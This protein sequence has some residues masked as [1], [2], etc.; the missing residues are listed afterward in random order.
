MSERVPAA[1]LVLLAAALALGGVGVAGALVFNLVTGTPEPARFVGPGTGSVDIEQPGRQVIW[2]EYST[3]FEGRRFKVPEVLPPGLKIRVAGPDGREIP[4]IQPG[5]STFKVGETER[6]VAAEFEAALPGRHLIVVTG[7]SDPRVFVVLPSLWR[8]VFFSIGGAIAAIFVGLGAAISV[9]LYAL[10]RQAS[11]EPVASAGYSGAVADADVD[12]KLR[13]L[14]AVVYGLQAASFLV[15]VTLIAAVIVNYIKRA[16]ARGTWLEAHFAWQIS[17][18][19]WSL[20]WS[21]LGIATAIFGIG[22]LI[23]LGAVVWFVYRIARGWTALND[24]R[25]PA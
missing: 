15:G 2:H 6:R 19:W 9:G 21:I 11:V 12:P 17:T 18:F 8:K 13:Q 25:P 22:L 10:L 1:R 23:L 5:R 3:V 16:D 4:L 20:L 7:R 14:T 24:G